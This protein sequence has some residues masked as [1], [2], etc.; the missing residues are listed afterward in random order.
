MDNEKSI[1]GWLAQAPSRIKKQA[2]KT[3]SNNN[4]S[5]QKLSQF[6]SFYIHFKLYIVIINIICIDVLILNVQ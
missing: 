3:N 1:K 4:D 6:L 2:E 5:S